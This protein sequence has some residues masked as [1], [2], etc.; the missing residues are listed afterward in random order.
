MSTVG[1]NINEVKGIVCRKRGCGYS[2][3]LSTGTDALH[4]AVKLV[5]VKPSDKEI[6]V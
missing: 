2:V 1:E 5:G 3:A 4:M 6:T